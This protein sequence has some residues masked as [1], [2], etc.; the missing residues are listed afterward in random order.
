MWRDELRQATRS[1]QD[2]MDYCGL[3]SQDIQVDYAP[4]FKI[5]VPPRWLNHI[6]KGNPH[7]P[8]LRQVLSDIRELDVRELDADDPLHE[9]AY[10]AVPGLLHKYPHRV[11]VIVAAACPIHCRYCFRRHFPYEKNIST[12][13]Q[14]QDIMHYIETTPEIYEVILSGGDPL[15]LGDERLGAML[16][17]I[18][19][20]P[21][22]RKIRIHTRFAT[23]IP[24]RFSED[25]WAMLSP[26]ASMIT[27]VWHIN[28]AQEL[29]CDIGPIVDKALQQGMRVL[30]QSVLLKGINDTLEALEDLVWALDKLKITPYYMH[31]VDQVRGAGHYEVAVNDGLVLMEAL[32][33]TV[34]GYLVPRYVKEIPHRFSKTPLSQDLVDVL[35]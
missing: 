19:S 12:G 35:I 30:S 28:H 1:V 25:F 17:D 8:L 20:L 4:D 23:T 34:P 7:D 32:R 14:W 26:Y 18:S 22:I 11:L 6:E 16:K 9:E 15:M 10:T 31:Q 24:S 2:L 27:W 5:F 13:K 3:T 21:S 33:N 29:S